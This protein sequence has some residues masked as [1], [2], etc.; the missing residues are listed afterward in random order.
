MS[1]STAGKVLEIG[2][3]SRPNV[4]AKLDGR[5]REARLMQQIRQELLGHVGESPSPVARALVERAVILSLHVAL[6]DARA[7][8][9]GGLSERD[10]RQYLAYSNSLGRALKQLGIKGAAAAGPTLQ[11]ALAEG[12]AQRESGAFAA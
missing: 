2:P 1:N 6:F 9:A 3:H 12:R 8:K 5:R 11:E 10:S 7:L 4:L